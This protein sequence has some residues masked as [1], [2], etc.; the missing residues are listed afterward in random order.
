MGR[1]R[2]LNK[3][4]R[5]VTGDIIFS[6]RKYPRGGTE[7][8][9]SLT[10]TRRVSSGEWHARSA[11]SGIRALP[12]DCFETGS[13][14]DVGCGGDTVWRRKNEIP[15]VGYGDRTPGHLFLD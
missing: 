7:T 5:D 8:R 14:A 3:T 13:F 12:R 15:E 9:R 11:P 10:A 6:E 2:F 4:V 1:K